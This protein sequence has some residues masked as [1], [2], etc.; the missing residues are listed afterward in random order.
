[1]WLKDKVALITG[2][3]SGIGE[4][5]ALAFGEQGA[6]VTVDYRSHAG[7]AEDVVKRIEGVGNEALVVHAD[8]T[9]P[10]DVSNLV[11]SLRHRLVCKALRNLR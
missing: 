7:E 11:H 3:S 4:A 5:I 2:A 6:T 10:E 9:N 1:M 8:V